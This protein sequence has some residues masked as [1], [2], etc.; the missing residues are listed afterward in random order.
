MNK[1]LLPRRA[2]AFGL[3]AS[4]F[5]LTAPAVAQQ[6][7]PFNTLQNQV[8]ALAGGASRLQATI[9]ALAAKVDLISTNGAAASVFVRWGNGSAP[10]GTSLIRSG[11]IYNGAWNA[12]GSGTAI[13]AESPA[14]GMGSFPAAFDH[15]VPTR[16]ADG[17]PVNQTPDSYGLLRCAVAL[18][19]GPTAVLWGSAV[20][21]PGWR[22]LYSGHA[23]GAS[24][25]N[26]NP[27]DRVCLDT[28]NIQSAPAPW[29]ANTAFYFASVFSPAGQAPETLLNCAVVVKES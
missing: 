23:V 12:Q 13:C 8:N 11:L 5:T 29:N 3:A 19:Q 24:A 17:V 9:D 20:A 10:V 27:A 4:L 25:A 28:G 18:A 15:M 14:S 1:V 26:A 22:V 21:P 7:V 6:G 2:V 16:L